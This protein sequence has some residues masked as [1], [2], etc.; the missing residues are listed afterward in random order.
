MYAEVLNKNFQ[1]WNIFPGTINKGNSTFATDRR[2][3]LIMFSTSLR[4][5]ATASPCIHSYT[6]SH[7]FL[8]VHFDPPPTHTHP[9][10]PHKH[11]LAWTLQTT[12]RNKT[13]MRKQW[14]RVIKKEP[15]EC[16]SSTK[17]VQ[18]FNNPSETYCSR[19]ISLSF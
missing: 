3:Q 1:C 15:N 5:S 18:A 10:P 12:D 9:T 16:K 11:P 6:H 13:E 8:L 2:T 17:G 4:F 19:L 7:I 14:E